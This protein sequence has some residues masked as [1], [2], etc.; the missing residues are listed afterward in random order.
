[1]LAAMPIS[2]MTVFVSYAYDSPIHVEWVTKLAKAVEELPGF[3]VIFDRFEM[4]GGKDVTH[5]MDRG[6]ACERILVVVTPE[7]I[8]KAGQRLG[9][10]GYESSVITAELL[11]NQLADR[12]VPVLR[13]GDDRPSFLKSKAFIDF[14]DDSAF[15]ASLAALRDALLRLPPVER[16]AK[17]TE[18]DYNSRPADGEHPDTSIV[19]PKRPLIVPSLSGSIGFMDYYGPVDIENIGDT[20]AFNIQISDI[21]NGSKV[22]RFS[23][24][25]RLRPGERFPAVPVIEGVETRGGFPNLYN[26]AWV[27]QI[28]HAWEAIARDPR[29]VPADE[30]ET[31]VSKVFVAPADVTYGDVNGGRWVTKAA[32]VFGRDNAGKHRLAIEMNRVE[33]S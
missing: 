33:R 3:H 29:V 15:D 13:Q 5:F 1:M 25:T 28:G 24:I 21:S 27:G 4:Y 14:R 26:F 11:E 32:M 16:P 31:L 8:R 7:Y 9:G 22:A 30:I 17:K 23:P 12:F 19:H 6:L 18:G 2:E 20:D 10:V